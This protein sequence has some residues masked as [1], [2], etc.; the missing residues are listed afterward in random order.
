MPAT[1]EDVAKAAGVST[2]T[3]SYVINA[4]KPVSAA[5]RARVEAA[6]AELGYRPSP[7]ARSL[8]TGQHHMLGLL[9]PDLAN[10]FFP[11]LAQAVAETARALGYGLMLSESGSDSASEEQALS[12]MQQRVDGIVWV[13]ETRQPDTRP[14]RPTVVIDRVGPDLQ[15]FDSVS[16]DHRMGGRLLAR[17]IRE[18]GH[19]RIGLLAGPA[20]S[21][22]AR[23]RREA[24][25]AELGD[26][27]PEWVLEVPYSSELPAAALGRLLQAG[28]TLIVAA[29]DAVAIAAL[30]ALKAHGRRVPEDVSLLGFDDIPWAT[31]VD[32]PLSTVSQ[33]VRAI[34]RSAVE[35]LHRRLGDQ[36]GAP[37]HLVLPVEYVARGST[38]RLRPEELRA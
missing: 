7:S 16:S 26:I 15:A 24:L 14:Y 20:D 9:L 3:V 19:R 38:R 17:A 29:N 33:P 13:P 36:G 27:Q 25:C 37:T 8:R 21:V 5:T 32:P 6:I 18:L 23:Q 31:L 12:A 30:R 34:G 4:A 28:P 10:P 11:A 22:S 1:L 35:L 2:A